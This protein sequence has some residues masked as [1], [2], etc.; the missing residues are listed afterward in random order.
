MKQQ[1]YGNVKYILVPSDL[2]TSAPLNRQTETLIKELCKGIYFGSYNIIVKQM[3][4]TIKT[5]FSNN[6]RI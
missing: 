6:K 5:L 3:C 1:E 4:R 2:C